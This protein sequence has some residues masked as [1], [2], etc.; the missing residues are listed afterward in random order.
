VNGLYWLVLGVMSVWRITHL[1]TF[2]DGP[3]RV[4]A[5]LRRTPGDGFWS[6]LFDCFYCLS[7]WIALPAA[8]A[9]GTGWLEKMLFWPSLSAGA[10]LLQGFLQRIAAAPAVYRE[11]K[12]DR[13]G[14]L[15]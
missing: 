3:W 11:E 14:M 7:L 9:I 6:D 10:I 2:E 12:E 15:R 4:I 8:L 5:N 1:L 13:D